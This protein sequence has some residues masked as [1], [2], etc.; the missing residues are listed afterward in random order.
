MTLSA[1]HHRL[2]TRVSSSTRVH[3]LRICVLDAQKGDHRVSGRET[4]VRGGGLGGGTG[5]QNLFFSGGSGGG[6][7]FPPLLDCGQ[8]N[9]PLC[10]HRS[11]LSGF[12]CP[13]HR[14]G[15]AI[16][17]WGYEVVG[18]GFPPLPPP[19]PP[20][21]I[22][23]PVPSF[24]FSPPVLAVTRFS[25]GVPDLFALRTPKDGTV[26]ARLADHW[27]VTLSAASAPRGKGG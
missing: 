3:A 17:D 22:A 11:T 12:A 26:W 23:G 14:K 27:R 21:R 4:E 16:Q 2:P 8:L 20:G 9:F 10:P 1:F 7:W 6:V 5:A 24:S 13:A 18:M 19:F 15:A 25:P